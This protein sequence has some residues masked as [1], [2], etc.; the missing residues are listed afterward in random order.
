VFFVPEAF[1]LF[2]VQLNWTAKHAEHAKL[3]INFAGNVAC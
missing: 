1:V 2:V 3:E